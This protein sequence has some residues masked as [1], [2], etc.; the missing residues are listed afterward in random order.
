[1]KKN[2]P[3]AVREVE[4]AIEISPNEPRF[5]HFRGFLEREFSGNIEAELAI[6]G[7][8]H[9]SDPQNF[10]KKGNYAVILIIQS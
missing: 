3:A 1:M 7:T 6:Y 10:Q 2:F 5:R 8:F 9:C 4:K